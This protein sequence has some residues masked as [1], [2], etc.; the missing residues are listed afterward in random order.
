MRKFHLRN[1]PPQTLAIWALAFGLIFV[2]IAMPSA[3]RNQAKFVGYT[4]MIQYI[5]E[6]PSDDEG[7]AKL[8]ISGDKWELHQKMI[9]LS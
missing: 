9:R 6:L 7:T 2:L 1:T 5:Q 4:E 3:P 8:I